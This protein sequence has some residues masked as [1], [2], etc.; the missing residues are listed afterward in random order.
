MDSLSEFVSDADL[1]IEAMN[2]LGW[3]VEMVSWRDR[4]ADW[5]SYDAVYICTPWDYQD[6]AAAFLRV[7]ERIEAS[8]ALLVNPLP[9]VRWNLEKTY[10][11]ELEASGVDIVPSRWFD[12]FDDSM[13]EALF[14]MH[15]ADRIVMKPVIGAN[16]DHTYVIERGDLGRSRR[17]RLASSFANRPFF[18]QPYL[19]AIESEGEYS[20]FVFG[21]EYSHAILKR[22]K[23][24]DF[25]SQEEHGA[26][27]LPVE[28]PCDLIG[29]AAKIAG[30]VD[31]EPAY[32]RA[33]FLRDGEDVFRLM[34]LELIE[35]SLYFRTNSDSTRRFAVAFDNHVRRYGHDTSN[36]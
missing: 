26:E 22:P 17:D 29:K 15:E 20:L 14:A 4:D 1:S 11:K 6:D 31:P 24:G 25:R 5:T 12:S 10:L 2:A 28:P 3:E 33:D 35:P 30:L 9:L 8:P 36:D 32:L 23:Q 21:G 16:A 13:P 34:E 27:I 19:D 18:V 7:L